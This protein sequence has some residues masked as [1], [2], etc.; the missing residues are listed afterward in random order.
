MRSG[1]GGPVVYW[2][3][4]EAETGLIWSMAGWF[5]Y[6]VRMRQ[7]MRQDVVRGSIWCA[8]ACSVISG[9]I[10]SPAVISGPAIGSVNSF[11]FVRSFVGSGGGWLVDATICATDM[12]CRYG[13]TICATDMVRRYARPEN[14]KGQEHVAP[15]P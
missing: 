13:A 2:Q 8:G 4:G 5:W 7:G 12:D 15:G 14:R 1:L 11:P 9:V 6:W 10:V 3:W